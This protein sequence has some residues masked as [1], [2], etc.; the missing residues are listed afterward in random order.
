[1]NELN[2]NICFPPIVERVVRVR[3]WNCLEVIGS[4]EN[5]IIDEEALLDAARRVRRCPL[6]GVMI[7]GQTP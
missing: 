3:C 1:M 7:G 5:N 4:T 6:C 2:H